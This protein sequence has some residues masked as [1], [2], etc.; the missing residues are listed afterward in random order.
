MATGMDF[1]R[2]VLFD[3]L[4]QFLGLRSGEARHRRLHLHLA[5][6][7]VLEPLV[8]PTTGHRQLI[9]ELFTFK[10]NLSTVLIQSLSTRKR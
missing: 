8:A 1:N 4:E 9:Y 2:R 5:Q 10:K 7:L 6:L 3:Q